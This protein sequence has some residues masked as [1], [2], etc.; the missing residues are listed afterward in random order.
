MTRLQYDSKYTVKAMNDVYLVIKVY[1]IVISY[2][3]RENS[4]IVPQI[5]I[6]NYD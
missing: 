2:Q 5:V 4:T 1:I 6:I 3:L